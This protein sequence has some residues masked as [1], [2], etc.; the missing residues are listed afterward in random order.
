MQPYKR[1]ARLHMHIGLVP[2]CMEVSENQWCG[3]AYFFVWW[4]GNHA[5]DCAS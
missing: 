5:K 3:C 1:F 2:R 4:Y